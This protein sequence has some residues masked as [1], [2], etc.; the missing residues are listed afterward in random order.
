MTVHFHAFVT[1]ALEYAPGASVPALR[2]LP[3][4][5]PCGLACEGGTLPECID[6]PTS[7]AATAAAQD[8]TEEVRRWIQERTRCFSEPVHPRAEG[9][10]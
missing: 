1:C 8:R 2:I 10:R 3:L 6:W 5:V 4:S 7:T 9:T